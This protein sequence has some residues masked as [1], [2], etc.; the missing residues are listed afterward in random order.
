MKYQVS[1]KRGLK[2]CNLGEFE[3]QDGQEAIRQATA[4]NPQYQRHDSSDDVRMR[5]DER[6][7]LP[8]VGEGAR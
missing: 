4:A 5:A 6:W 8:V 3:A 2:W 1:V 7:A